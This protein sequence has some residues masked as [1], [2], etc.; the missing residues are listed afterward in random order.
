MNKFILS[1]E[2]YTEF[3]GFLGEN[4]ITDFNVRVNL[5]GY[6]CSGPAFN[7][8]VEEPKENDIVEKVNDITFLL[9]K[10]L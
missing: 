6:G 1:E 3:K 5:A 4:D 8:S 2:A 10:I 7:I 9:K